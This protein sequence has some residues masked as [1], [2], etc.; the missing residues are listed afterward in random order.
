MTVDN[1]EDAIERLQ[2]SEKLMAELNET[3]EEKLQKADT[4]KKEREAV[5]SEM[6]LASVQSGET[7]GVFSPKK[8]P[9]LVN[10]NED[11]FMS[12]CLLYYLKVGETKVG[13][14]SINNGIQLSGNHIL[15]Y[16]CSFFNNNES[17]V[18]LVPAEGALVYINGRQVTEEVTLKTGS[19]VILGKNHV[20]RFNSPCEARR[21]RETPSSDMPV[22]W[23]FAQNE[24][25]EKQGV[26]LKCEME[27]RLKELEDEFK[28]AREKNDLELERQRKH[29]ETKIVELQEQMER[30]SMVSSMFSSIVQD[31]DE[32]TFEE[33]N[34]TEREFQLASWAFAKWKSYQFTS[35]RD[36]LWSNAVYLKEANAISVELKKNVE[37]QFRLL[38][39]TM[40]SPVP[41]DI[42]DK[43][44][45]TIVAV[46]VN[47]KKNG[48]THLWSLSKLCHR[49]EIMKDMYDSFSDGCLQDDSDGMGDDPFYDRFPWFTLIGR[50]FLYLTNLTQ[51]LSLTQSLAI[52]DELGKV[53]GYMLISVEIVNDD[54]P[55]DSVQSGVAKVTFDD[56]DDYFKKFSKTS[57]DNEN[58]SATV[59]IGSLLKFKISVKE[60]A[61]FSDQ[62]NDIFCQFR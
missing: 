58:N 49:L 8:T 24:L 56:N 57:T 6:G 44:V 55:S 23:S 42:D 40:Y 35:L 33:C 26:D 47:D 38:T 60:I 5:L 31:E 43:R 25:L 51:P 37:F 4:I 2:M 11:P 52:V 34:W 14:P 7:V 48:A 39:D 46:S 54:T 13:R 41:N 20:F 27:T 3:W 45:K 53:N 28:R 30:Q 29:Y 19:R 62:F 15:D 22:D 1:G 10:L 9:H 16:H 32:D 18:T 59:E 61:C 36:S 12:E 17:G 50:S 21:E